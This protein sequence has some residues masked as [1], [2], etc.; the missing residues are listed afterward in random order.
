[1]RVSHLHQIAASSRLEVHEPRLVARLIARVT[2]SAEVGGC[3]DERVF[4]R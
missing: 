4:L 3:P 2:E 1:M